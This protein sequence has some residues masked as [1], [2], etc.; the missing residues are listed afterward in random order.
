MRVEDSIVCKEVETL[1][2]KVGGVEKAKAKIKHLK[3]VLEKA[4]AAQVM[5]EAVKTATEMV[6]EVVQR[7]VETM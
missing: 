1:R 5:T 4:E 6:V 7:K 2:S 3:E